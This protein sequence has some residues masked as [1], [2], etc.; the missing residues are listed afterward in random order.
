MKRIVMLLV[1]GAFLM[2]AVAPAYAGPA[3][4]IIRWVKDPC[5]PNGGLE[6]DCLT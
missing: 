6:D 4:K 2:G 1:T 5:V 3:D